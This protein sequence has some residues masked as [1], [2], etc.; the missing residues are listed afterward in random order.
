MRRHIIRKGVWMGDYCFTY[1]KTPYAAD[2]EKAFEIFNSFTKGI[3]EKWITGLSFD[4]HYSV[5]MHGNLIESNLKIRLNFVDF[6]KG[7]EKAEGII[8]DLKKRKLIEN[9][10]KWE[11][12]GDLD[13]VK[14][15]TE[16]A[17]KCACLLKEELDRDAYAKSTFLKNILL[18]ELQ[19][20]S[21]LLNKLGF[22]IDFQ[23]YGPIGH[24]ESIAPNCAEKLRDDF[25]DVDIDFLERFLHHFRNCMNI[26]LKMEPTIK[27]EL[28]YRKMLT[29]FARS[30]NQLKSA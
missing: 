12:F 14:R 11:N 26:N 6:N 10:S 20:E 29:D 27:F 13:I 19:F 28:A 30:K 8:E 9:K 4:R 24:V 2:F 16:V 17:T 1:L 23:K 21:L 18:F 3:A 22:Q 25:R 15:A 7:K 5:D